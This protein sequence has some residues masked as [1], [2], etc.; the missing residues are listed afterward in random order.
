MWKL[1]FIT[2]G[3]SRRNQATVRQPYIAGSDVSREKAES[4]YVLTTGLKKAKYVLL[5]FE[6]RGKR[7]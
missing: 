1:L 4:E 6:D 2:N 7:I 3:V 5:I